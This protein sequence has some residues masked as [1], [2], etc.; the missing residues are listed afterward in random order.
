MCD[1]AVFVGNPGRQWLEQVGRIL[2][3]GN[4]DATGVALHLGLQVDVRKS[5]GPAEKFFKPRAWRRWYARRAPYIQAGLLHCRHATNGSPLDN[6]NNHPHVSDIGSVLVHRGVVEP[7]VLQPTHSEYDSEQLLASLDRMGLE[8]G[9]LNCPGSK[10]VAYIP[11]W[12]LNHIYIYSNS[13]LST[14]TILGTLL[15]STVRFEGATA[16]T[17]YQW[18]K[19]SL[20]GKVEK[21]MGAINERPRGIR[22]QPDQGD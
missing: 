19:V 14:L 1:I 9:I 11:A 10:S 13:Q 21:V 12:D 18:Y 4:K 5:P 2:Q 17:L 15:I 20:N 3:S 7:V 8:K 16:L 22:L 6:K